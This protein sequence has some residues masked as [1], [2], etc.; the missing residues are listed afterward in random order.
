MTGIEN[1]D[2]DVE[3]NEE[4]RPDLNESIEISEH[5]KKELSFLF[6]PEVVE[7]ANHIDIVDLN[8]NN[9][10]TEC[11]STGVRQ[12]KSLKNDPEAQIKLVNKMTA[13]ERIVLCMWIMEMDL[14]EKIQSGSYLN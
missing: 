11:I 14:L 12:L 10:I 3:T 1:A 6:G 7:Q 2:P 5:L 13:G 8:L 4:L 9:E